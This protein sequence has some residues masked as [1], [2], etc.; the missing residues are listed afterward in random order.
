M[1]AGFTRDTP[2]DGELTMRNFTLL[3]EDD[4]NEARRIEFSGHE[5]RDAF[6]LL[7]SERAARKATLWES[8]IKLGTIVRTG[9]EFWEISA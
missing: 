1:Y 6:A 2:P 4:G 3:L 8:E 9:G 7:E 5:P